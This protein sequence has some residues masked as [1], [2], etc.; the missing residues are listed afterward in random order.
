MEGTKRDPEGDF[1]VKKGLSIVPGE[2]DIAEILE[3][4]G[5][6]KSAAEIVKIEK[7]YWQPP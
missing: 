2:V 5:H 7:E 1:R 3:M 6:L 4:E